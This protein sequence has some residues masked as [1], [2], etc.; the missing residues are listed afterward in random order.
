MSSYKPCIGSKKKRSPRYFDRIGDS[1]DD[2]KDDRSAKKL[3]V[4][5]QRERRPDCWYKS[6]C[7]MN[8]CA[9]THQRSQ[10]DWTN[11]VDKIRKQRDAEIR[12]QK[13]LK[14]LYDDECDIN[15]ENK[16]NIIRLE[17]LVNEQENE[18]KRL[19]NIINEL[20]ND[21]NALINDIQNKKHKVR[22]GLKTVYNTLEYLHHTI[23]TS[24]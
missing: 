12:E 24:N 23:V 15:H 13:R 8:D 9:F 17:K 10:N 19:H 5:K 20:E 7:T 2:S 3:K 6:N 14:R 11:L 1:K 4:V 18:N 16:K 22:E 21:K